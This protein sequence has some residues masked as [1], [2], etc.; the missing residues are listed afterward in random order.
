MTTIKDL[1]DCLN[2]ADLL[3]IIDIEKEKDIDG[4]AILKLLDQGYQD[5]LPKRLLQAILWNRLDLI[6]D[7][8][9]EQGKLIQDTALE[10]VMI[11]CLLEEKIDVVEHVQKSGFS[12][13]K[14]LTQEN[15]RIL[16]NRI[17]S[18]L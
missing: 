15:L 7:I 6:D 14:F 11:T 16:Y 4:K 5:D 3:E 2:Y 17:V 12:F 9:Y 18:I 10:D 1:E 8:I 13:K